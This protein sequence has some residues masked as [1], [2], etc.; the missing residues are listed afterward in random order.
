MWGTV[1][2]FTGTL[3]NAGGP[4]FLAY[5]LPQQLAKMTL[6]GTMALYFTA[7]NTMKIVPYFALG[8]FSTRNLTTSAVLL[9]FAVAATFLGVRLMRITP[10][11]VFYRLAY[12]MVFCIALALIWQGATGI[13]AARA[14]AQ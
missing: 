13:L 4:P 2:G 11:Q 1:S 14:M 9:P 7:L 10:A 6:V 12:V 8:Q 3:A 5:V